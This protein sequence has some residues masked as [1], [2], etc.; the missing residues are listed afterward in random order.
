MYLEAY[1]QLPMPACQD[2]SKLNSQYQNELTNG[3]HILGKKTLILEHV[4]I[5][6]V[7]QGVIK[8]KRIF[9][10]PILKLEEQPACE[11]RN[12]CDCSQ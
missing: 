12:L 10:I 6:N 2:L 3:S 5:Y 8:D 1:D 9:L 11:C 7:Q 4:I